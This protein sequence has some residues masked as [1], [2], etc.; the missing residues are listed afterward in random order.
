MTATGP[1]CRVPRRTLAQLI[2][3][4]GS[5]YEIGYGG[6]QWIAAR[7]DGHGVL[8]ANT[9]PALE[10]VIEADYRH[11]PV[12]REFD[13]PGSDSGAADDDED[14]RLPGRTKGFCWRPCKPP[15]RPGPS[16]TAARCRR[17]SRGHGRRR[18]ARVRQCCCARRWWAPSAATA[19]MPGETSHDA[20]PSTTGGAPGRQLARRRSLPGAGGRWLVPARAA[21]RG[22]GGIVHVTCKTGRWLPVADRRFREMAGGAAG[23]VRRR[24][25]A[26]L[27]TGGR[28]HRWGFVG[29]PVSSAASARGCGSARSSSTR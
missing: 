11:R 29:S 10:I 9:L 27:A 19:S 21:A 24:L 13:P 3:G 1:A 22:Q 14:A 15:S 6:D 12:P 2:W 17:G 20:A 16:A 4:W 8:A 18:S 23:R 7:R 5:A 28:V 25:G 26:V